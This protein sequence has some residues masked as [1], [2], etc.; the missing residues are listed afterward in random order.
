MANYRVLV[1][2]RLPDSAHTRLDRSFDVDLHD[3]EEQLPTPELLE[4]VRG[5][6]GVVAMVSDRVDGAFLDAA[7]EELRVVAN[8]AVGY[9]NIDVEAATARGVVVTN[10]PD[11]L[12][13]ATAELTLSVMLALARRVAE[14]DRLL[15][16]KTPWA[17]SPTWMIG[18]GLAGCTLGIV[19]LGRIGKEVAR[20]ASAFGMHVIYT[21]HSGPAA[22]MAYESVSLR[23]LLARADVVSL[24]CPLTPETRHLIGADELDAMK[25]EAVLVNTARGPVVDENALV[26]ALRGGQIAGAAL[27]VFEREPELHAGLRELDNVVLTPHLGSGTGDTREAMSELCFSALTAVLL[28]RRCPPNALNPTAMP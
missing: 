11:V 8:Y 27:D 5:V 13:A 22:G 24:H 15:R 28:E 23:E 3:S 25:D 20:L 14:G 4:R 6:A 2:R 21:N 26:E 19:G 18:T 17:W 1:T 10:T 7:G 12:S 9:D 16:H